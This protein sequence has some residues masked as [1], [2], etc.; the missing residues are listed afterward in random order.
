MGKYTDPN[1]ENSAL[2]TIDTQNDFTLRERPLR[3][4]APW[5]CWPACGPR[6]GLQRRGQAHLP[7]C[8]ALPT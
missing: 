8:Q 4:P 3:S 7:R 1:W 5:T 6:G 2:V